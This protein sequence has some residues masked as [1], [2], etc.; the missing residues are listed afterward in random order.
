MAYLFEDGKG[1][2]ID[3]IHG[4]SP[5]WSEA[6][7]RAIFSLHALMRISHREEPCKWLPSSM[8][9]YHWAKQFF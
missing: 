6:R 1:V 8:L 9:L 7:F 4:H 2:D 5:W 3:D